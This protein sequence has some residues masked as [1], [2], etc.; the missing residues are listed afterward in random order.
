MPPVLLFGLRKRH[1]LAY[2]LLLVLLP[3]PHLLSH[4]NVKTT[5]VEDRGTRGLQ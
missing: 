1:Y 4:E 3:D 5:S 2:R